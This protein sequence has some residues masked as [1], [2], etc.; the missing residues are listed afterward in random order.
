M[1]N[2]DS[3]VK[4]SGFLDNST[5][6]VGDIN[7]HDSFRIDGNF[8]GVIKKGDTLIIGETGNVEADIEVNNIS[9]NGKFKGTVIAREQIEIFPNG[10]VTGKIISPKLII[11]EGAFFQGS[12]Q[13]NLKALESARQEEKEQSYKFEKKTGDNVIEK[14]NIEKKIK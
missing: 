9:I 13:M 8:K 4:V 3:F 2:N 11:K 6:I 1:K 12:C 10:S 7:F 14:E 5:T